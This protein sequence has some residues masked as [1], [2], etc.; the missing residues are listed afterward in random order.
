MQQKGKL[1]WVTGL[2][3]SGKTTIG[4]AVYEKLK[5]KYDNTVFLD[6]DIFRE[7]LGNDLGHTPK[8]RLENAKRIHKMCKFLI[9]QDI[10]VVCATMSLYKEIHDLNRKEIEE[11]FEIFIECTIEELIKR[12]Q[13]GLYSKALKGQ[14]DDV[15]GV[16]LPYDRP[17]NCELIIENSENNH[18]NEKVEQILNLI[19]EK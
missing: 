13:K 9:S 12:D 17:H 5:K 18:L 11:Y 14:R 19:G 15:V 2:S 3:G 7:V 6:G 16:N 10:N 4:K 8:D 1:I